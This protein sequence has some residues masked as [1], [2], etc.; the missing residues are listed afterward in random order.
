MHII[1]IQEDI[2]HA[3]LS[4]YQR[5]YAAAIAGKN[6]SDKIINCNLTFLQID[7]SRMSCYPRSSHDGP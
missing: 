4:Q 2:N 3:N 1:R 7:N 5:N 6:K